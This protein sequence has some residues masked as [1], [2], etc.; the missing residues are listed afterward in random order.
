MKDDR[1]HHILETVEDDFRFC[2]LFIADAYDNKQFTFAFI[3]H[4]FKFGKK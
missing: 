1:Y 3:A 4:Q 2:H